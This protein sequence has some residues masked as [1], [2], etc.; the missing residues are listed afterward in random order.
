MPKTA[1]A[2]VLALAL[3][4]A[5]LPAL[6]QPT[7]GPS[8]LPLPRFVSMASNEV[9]VRT[10]P[11]QDYP[12][13]WTYVRRDLPVKIVEEFDVWRKIQDPDGEEG[14]VH[15]SLLSSKRTALV[16][17]AIEELHRTA[18]DDSRVVL[19]A[20]PGVVGE[21]IDCTAEWCLLEIAERRGWARRGGIW[22]VLDGEMQG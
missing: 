17:G 21:L 1:R 5:A 7:A 8:G 12:I 20:E 13:K 10:G 15:S 2:L 18:S 19:R 9:N 16:V 22:G 6:A 3:A 11:G 4:G 14:W